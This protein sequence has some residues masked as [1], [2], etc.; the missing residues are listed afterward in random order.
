M[1]AM[2]AFEGPQKTS[3]KGKIEKKRLNSRR[4]VPDILFPQ[5]LND[6]GL[7]CKVRD[8]GDIFFCSIL[9]Y[10][11]LPLSGLMVCC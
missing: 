3:K 6:L 4:E 1:A 11:L 5:G 8:R 7:K 2:G 10:F 9:T